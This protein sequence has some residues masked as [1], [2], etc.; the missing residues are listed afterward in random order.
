MSK[1]FEEF[2]KIAMKMSEQRKV[3]LE[4]F[5]V[6]YIRTLKA[7]EVE[8]CSPFLEYVD[9]KPVLQQRQIKARKIFYSLCKEDGTPFINTDG[10]K[11]MKAALDVIE[12]WPSVIVNELMREIDT[13]N[14]LTLSK[15][16]VEAGKDN[17][18]KEGL[19]E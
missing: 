14:P 8:D 18:Q 1:A 2:A 15:E 3:E 7:K 16:E 19:H 4:G 9:G 12:S 5:P 6:V 13:L 17:D 11:D 10:E